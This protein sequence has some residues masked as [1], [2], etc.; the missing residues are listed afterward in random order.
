MLEPSV[1]VMGRELVQGRRLQADETP[2]D[3][4]MHDECE[5]RITTSSCMAVWP[6]GRAAFLTSVS[7]RERAGP[8]HFLKKFRAFCRPMLTKPM[9]RW[10]DREW[11]RLGA[12]R[13]P[14]VV[15]RIS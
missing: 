14:V 3:V 6:T 2:V 15:L 9:T 11:H 4:Q 8:Q 5:G 12:G 10:E 7:E 1:E 13:T